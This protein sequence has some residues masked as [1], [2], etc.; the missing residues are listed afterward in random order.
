MHPECKKKKPGHIAHYR[1]HIVP[2]TRLGRSAKALSTRFGYRGWV[3]FTEEP[4]MYGV[5]RNGNRIW[6]NNI[7]TKSRSELC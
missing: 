2:Y 1:L 3:F 4:L 6:Y 7:Q 5:L